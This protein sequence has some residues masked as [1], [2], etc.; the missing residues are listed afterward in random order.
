MNN[1]IIID[2]QKNQKERSTSMGKGWDQLKKSIYSRRRGS[3]SIAAGSLHVRGKTISAFVNF[4]KI[5]QTSSSVG[6]H[7]PGDWQV[8]LK[9]LQHLRRWSRF[10]RKVCRRIW[11]LWKEA[12]NF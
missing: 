1:K 7:C 9:C 6:C 12:E 5:Q 4:Q 3:A 8:R 2:G 10:F 11:N